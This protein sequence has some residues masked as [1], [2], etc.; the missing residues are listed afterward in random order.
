MRGQPSRFIANM[1][2]IAILSWKAEEAI[3]YL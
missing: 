1:I 3:H 2:R